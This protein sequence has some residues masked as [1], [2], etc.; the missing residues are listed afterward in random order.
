VQSLVV[1][2][3]LLFLLLQ[4]G[5]GFGCA[6]KAPLPHPQHSQHP[7]CITRLVFDQG[8]ESAA[9]GEGSEAVRL[10]G[11]VYTSPVVYLPTFDECLLS[12]NVVTPG[13]SGV[14]FEARVRLLGADTGWSPWLFMGEAGDPQGLITGEPV[15][16]WKHGR[17]AVDIIEGKAIFDAVQVRARGAPGR[18]GPALIER[19]EIV[20]TSTPRLEKYP[21][22]RADGA[23]GGLQEIVL[24]VPFLSQRTSNEALSGRLCSPTSVAMVLAYYGAERTVEEV[25]GLVHDARHDIYGNWPRNVQAARECGVAGSVTRFAS[26]DEVAVTLAQGKPIIASIVV[27]PGELP[28]APYGETDGHLIVITGMT[29]EGDLLVNDPACADEG[30]G[31]LVYPRDAMERVWL[32][33]RKGTA[34]VLDGV[35][36][37]KR[38]G[39]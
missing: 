27:G 4:A 36:G 7:H 2:L 29:A 31:R 15:T 9:V 22:G 8:G 39:Q 16:T 33:S 35:V 10:G 3:P 5:A 24:D 30:A 25:A 34:Y 12:W 26:W 18:G 13:G 32:V 23:R 6:G 14:V 38:E 21:R 28:G 20:T 17:V 37:E 11:G 19:L 1:L